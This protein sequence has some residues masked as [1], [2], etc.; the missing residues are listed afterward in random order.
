MKHRWTNWWSKKTS[1]LTLNW[2]ML[3]TNLQSL[4]YKILICLS[5]SICSGYIYGG[6]NKLTHVEKHRQDGS[7][8]NYVVFQLLKHIRILLNFVGSGISITMCNQV[9]SW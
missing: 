3:F 4:L 9:V 5:N 6:R 1:L 7:I 2:G 8:Y